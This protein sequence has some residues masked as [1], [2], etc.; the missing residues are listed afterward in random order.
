MSRTYQHISE[1]VHFKR[2]RGFDGELLPACGKSLVGNKSLALGS[3]ERATANSQTLVV[4]CFAAP[5]DPGE[6][7]WAATTFPV[8]WGAC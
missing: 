2:R 1:A 3:I 5:K 8:S 6:P 4:R 7:W